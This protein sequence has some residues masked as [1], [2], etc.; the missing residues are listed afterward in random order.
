MHQGDIAQLREK[1]VTPDYIE[2]LVQERMA[3]MRVEQHL[4]A[5]LVAHGQ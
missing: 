2:K 1:L 3:S 4:H 5:D